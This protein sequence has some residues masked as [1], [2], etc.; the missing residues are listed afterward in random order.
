MDF[1]KKYQIEANFNEKDLRLLRGCPCGVM[2]KAMDYGII[3]GEFV[4]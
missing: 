1:I 3:V 2:V 4:L